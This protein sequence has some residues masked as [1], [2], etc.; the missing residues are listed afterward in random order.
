MNLIDRYIIKQIIQ[1]L[2]FVLMA[3]SLIFIIIN[4]TDRSHIFM[5]SKV[6]LIITVKYYLVYLPEIL[7]ILTPV[8]ILISCL[9]VIGRLSNNNEIIIMKSGGMSLSRLLFPVAIL[10]I[11]FSILQFL[12][13]GWV[14]PKA[15]LEKENISRIELNRAKSGNPISQ[16]TFRDSPNKNVLI[17]YYDPMSQK[18]YGLI[19]EIYNENSLPLPKLE[20]KIEAQT[21]I[22]NKTQ[23]EWILEDVIYR[24][25]VSNSEITTIRY[26][27]LPVELNINVNQMEKLSRKIDEMT[28]NEL[29][30]Y[31]EL[32]KNGGKDIKRL[33][34]DYYSEQAL[35]LA[36]FIVVLFAVGFASVKKKNGLAT[37]IAAAM[38]ITF[39]YLIFFKMFNPIGIELNM[40]PQL[41]GWS[42][43]IL[44]II[45]GTITIFKTRT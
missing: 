11:L 8:S 30:E 44:F 36:N 10:G 4:F 43:N 27:S 32:L 31:I 42:A 13:N 22:W 7:K 45:V 15:N 21:I 5:D 23:K 28:F 39:T 38:I 6:K 3:L 1:T 37:Q 2:F 33:E 24:S 41:I 18:G 19:L 20:T 25:I 35:P 34:V 16:L 40:P 12:F 14:V 29:K 17:N 9:F 26:D